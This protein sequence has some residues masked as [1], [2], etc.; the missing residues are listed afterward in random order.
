MFDLR[1]VTVGIP[2]DNFRVLVSSHQLGCQLQNFEHIFHTS[3]HTLDEPKK[4]GSWF[5]LKPSGPSEEPHS[6]GVQRRELQSKKCADRSKTVINIEDVVSGASGVESGDDRDGDR[7]DE[8]AGT[9]GEWPNSVR[10]RKRFLS[11]QDS[12]ADEPSGTAL[13]FDNEEGM[14]DATGPTVAA[15][16]SIGDDAIETRAETLTKAK[17]VEALARGNDMDV[18]NPYHFSPPGDAPAQTIEHCTPVPLTPCSP[19]L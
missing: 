16:A 4:Y 6:S 3:L 2:E 1:P 5:S 7:S 9:E 19:P 12:D 13:Q 17:D 11:S 8:G 15:A 10:K 14:N 18:E